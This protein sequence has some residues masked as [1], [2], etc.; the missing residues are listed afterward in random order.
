V[1]IPEYDEEFRQIGAIC[2]RLFRDAEAKLLFLVDKNGQLIHSI[3]ASADLDVTALSSLTAGNIEAA[4]GLTQLIE[5]K[6]FSICFPDE[7]QR[8]DVV[9]RIIAERVIL[10]V[11]F[12]PAARLEEVRAH[13]AKAAGLIDFVLRSVKWEPGRG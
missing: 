3:G 5:D 11:F 1:S 2:D 13:V 12:V 6:E 8:D 9:I 7:E 10:S 4:G